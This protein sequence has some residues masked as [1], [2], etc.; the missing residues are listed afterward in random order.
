MFLVFWWSLLTKV[1]VISE[2]SGSYGLHGLQKMTVGDQNLLGC[3]TEW[4]SPVD[5]KLSLLA[6]ALVHEKV[7]TLPIKK[8]T[9]HTHTHFV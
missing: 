5:A 4:F 9:G 6:T 1:I 2:S 7:F 8:K 3:K